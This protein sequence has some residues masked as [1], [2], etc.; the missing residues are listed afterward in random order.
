MSSAPSAAIAVRFSEAGFHRWPDPSARRRYLG[1]RHRHLFAVTVRVA[2]F[3]GDRE[4]EFHDLLAVS[5]RLF[6]SLAQEEPAALDIP[7]FGPQSCETLATRLAH[8]LRAV[9]P[10][11]GA[12]M[13]MVEV[14]EDNEVGAEV[15]IP[16]R[17]PD[18]SDA[19]AAN[20]ALLL[21][22]ESWEGR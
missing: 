18:S 11:G 21:G 12:R 20:A 1:E 7:D 4:V 13:V 5:R 17:T 16:A 22:Y 10:R 2:V 9:L 14:W 19:A 8:G 15:I 6:L 3:H